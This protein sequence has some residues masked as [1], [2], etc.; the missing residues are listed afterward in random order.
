MKFG[1]F[2]KPRWKHSDPKIRAEA[3]R[4]MEDN[5]VQ[6]LKE[7]ALSDPT[8]DNRKAA[9]RKISDEVVLFDI[10]GKS[11]DKGLI[12][13]AQKKLT[14]LWVKKIRAEVSESEALELLNKIQ[15]IKAIEDIATSCPHLGVRAACLKKLN[16]PA[17]FYKVALVE[18]N[19]ELALQALDKVDKNLH[20][21]ALA[22]KAKCKAVRQK[23]KERSQAQ[24]LTP[25]LPSKEVISA[26]KFDLLCRSMEDLQTPK[27]WSQAATKAK[28]TEEV[29]AS[30]LREG[31]PSSQAQSRW[32]SAKSS[33]WAL[34]TEHELKHAQREAA[35]KKLRDALEKREELCHRFDQLLAQK[36]SADRS[37]QID[38]IQS[39]W[40]EL[41]T[42]SA[43]EESP[44]EIRYKQLIGSYRREKE[45]QSKNQTAESSSEAI[46]SQLNTLASGGLVLDYIDRLGELRRQAEEIVP[47][48]KASEWLAAWE[49]AKN[50]Q[51]AQKQTQLDIE[52]KQISVLKKL[53]AEFEGLVEN[54][55]LVRAEKNYRDL[56]HEWKNAEEVFV[57]HSEA[58]RNELAQLRDAQGKAVGQFR[59]SLEW[60]RWA[61]LKKK[62]EICDKLEASL[63][64]EV[65]P[66]ALYHKWREI[67]NDWKN[68]GPVS[69]ENTK[70]T[71]DR[72]R[73]LVDEVYE[74]C[75]SFFADL[76]AERQNNLS[77]KEKL[78]QSVEAQIGSENWRESS[79][80][81]K[82]AQTKWKDIGPVPKEFSESLWERFKSLCDQ[83]Y[84][85]RKVHIEQFEKGKEENLAKKIALCELVEQHK[86]SIDWKATSEIFKNAQKDWK[87]TGPVPKDQMEALWERFRTACDAF[88]QNR[89]K[90]FQEFNQE[91]DENLKKKL[92]LCERAEAL[93][94]IEDEG[95]RFE[96]IKTL[97]AEWK[98]VG[99]VPKDQIQPLWDRFRG[100]IDG[101]F[102]GR[103]QKFEDDKEQRD[104]NLI[105]KNELVAAAEVLTQSSD[106][107]KSS[108]QLKQLQAQWKEVGPAPREQDRECWQKFR[109]ACDLF[110]NRMK[111]H[112]KQLDD[113]RE[114]N[115]RAKLDICYQ[116]E[117]LA[118][119]EKE[120]PEGY[121]W[122]AAAEQVKDLQRK[123][124]GT[125]PVPKTKGDELW[126]RFRMASDFVF[127]Y[128]RAV[129]ANETIDLAKNLEA[130]K[131]IAEEADRISHQVHTDSQIQ[132][133]R[134]LQRDWK[135]NGPVAQSEFGALW[136]TF[137]TACEH[138]FAQD[139]RLRE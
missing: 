107:K 116:A 139:E 47:S 134:D 101:F 131:Q 48:E 57:L 135:M 40:S 32:E 132:K 96:A 30:L 69:W 127:D 119:W 29:W 70:E 39:E 97:Q 49:D 24:E 58:I 38:V 102:E 1:D 37:K 72:Y 15:E 138:V 13:T 26:A 68:I 75:Q 22:K 19:T 76:A 2:F 133:I 8:I 81:V 105:K 42:V 25:D 18:T 33:F 90:H 125:G 50:Y 53:V 44:F 129:S 136:T 21:E 77:E 23:A 95:E 36:P 106:W 31:V 86:D 114:L 6:N 87:E 34:H 66:K 82:E 117:A 78:C 123:W 4:E 91:K 71:W 111:E 35:E 80:L 7:I 55:D 94:T 9:L 126:H 89:D 98:A 121:D 54:P 20:L 103:K 115:L 65:D 60:F 28:E 85:G 92:A 104:A 16:N 93:A 73:K 88:F 3:I 62:Q 59:E 10:V 99:P 11:S 83:F 5:Q 120:L 100:P 27:N 108:E 64:N 41:K 61:N 63:K 137:R 46:V 112:Y 130:R 74:K 113:M 12:D 118:H 45:L 128:A 109:A 51:E 14:E 17:S 124:K 52:N 67:Q 84:Q 122:V 79:D 43:E 56:V 110:F